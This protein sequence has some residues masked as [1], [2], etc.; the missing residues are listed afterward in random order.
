MT[1]ENTISRARNTL[2]VLG[3]PEPHGALGRVLEGFC[4]VVVRSAEELVGPPE[5]S[6]YV[7]GDL[8]RMPGG[9]GRVRVVRELSTGG[10]VW[11]DGVEAEV[12]GVGRVPLLVHGAGV[13]FPRFFEERD[14]FT[15]VQDEHEFQELTESTKKSKALRTGIYLTDVAQEVDGDGEEVLRYRLLRCSSN[16]TGPT[17]NFRA[18]DRMIMDG[19][20]AAASEVFDDETELNHV[21]AQVYTNTKDDDARGRERKAKISAHSDK[22][23][24]MRADGLIAFC[25]FYDPEGFGALTPSGRDPFDWV[26]GKTSGLTTLYFKLK[27]TV[28]ERGGLAEEFSVTLYPN[29]VFVIPL[30]TNR[31]YTH[32]IR[33]SLLNVDRLPTRMGYVARSSKAEAVWAGGKAHLIEDGARIPL[34]PMTRDELSALRQSYYQE[35]RTDDAV[36]YGD[37]RFSMNEGDYAKPLE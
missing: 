31:L 5:A 4:G 24:D 11:P 12:V 36:A 25:T 9:L 1:G 28:A 32:A 14:L 34:T 8:S 7:C 15:R 10:E 37:V 21:L 3:E 23:K 26:H 2:L 19:I 20:N 18:T 6:L 27:P 29:S 33:P 30:S 22:T 35:N 16:L 17:D 13:F